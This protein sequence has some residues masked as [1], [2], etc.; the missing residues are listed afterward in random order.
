MKKFLFSSFLSLSLLS[1]ASVALA[2][3]ATPY[4]STQ[5]PAPVKAKS[6]S[7]QA[8]DITINN[9]TDQDIYLSVPNSPINDV[10]RA[11]GGEDHIYNDTWFGPTE[12]RLATNCGM[13]FFDNNVDNHAHVA[14]FVQ[15][16]QYV[17]NVN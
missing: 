2:A 8:T 15:Q 5:H 6:G 11:N 17:V 12:I 10:I 16:G 7:F 9:Y 14:V 3:P 1:L 13:V 4:Y